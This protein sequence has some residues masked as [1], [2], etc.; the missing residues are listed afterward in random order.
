MTKELYLEDSYLK[1]CEAQIVDIDGDKVVLDQTVVYPGGGGQEEDTGYLIQDEKE[2]EIYKITKEN[3]QLVH[4]VKHREELQKN[5]VIVK[6]DWDRRY[7]L[8]RHHSLLH[9][10]AAVVYNKYGSLCTG[11][12]IYENRARIDFNNLSN[13]TEEQIKEI[14]DETNRTISSNVSI[15]SR[16]VSREEAEKIS[17]VI[18]TVVNLIPSSVMEIRLV[19]IDNIDEQACGGTHVKKSNEIGRLHIGKVKSKGKNNKRIDVQAV[20]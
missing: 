10:L 12:Q 17:G 5:K 13:L 7:G 18:K 2:F 15:T 11:N 16:Y 1:E 3:G 20:L 4:Y 19:T 6:I 9:V 14:E 8:M